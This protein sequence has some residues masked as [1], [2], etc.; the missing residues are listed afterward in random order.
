[1]LASLT[2]TRFEDAGKKLAKNLWKNLNEIQ[3]I[4]GC[5]KIDGMLHF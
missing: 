2:I 5:N 1:M 3:Y 4:S